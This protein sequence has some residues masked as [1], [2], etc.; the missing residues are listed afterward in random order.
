[1]RKSDVVGEGRFL[2]QHETNIE[3]KREAMHQSDGGEGGQEEGRNRLQ[4][5]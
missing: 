4:K 3:E 2:V 1:M 5:K